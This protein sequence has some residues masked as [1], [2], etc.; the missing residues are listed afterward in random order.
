MGSPKVTPLSESFHNGGFIVSEVGPG[1]LS[2]EQVILS[3]GAKAYAGAVLGKVA[4]GTSSATAGMAASGLINLAINP[5]DG[6]TVTIVGTAITF[7]ASGASGNFQVNIGTTPTLT[8]AALVALLTAHAIATVTCTAQGNTGIL[9][10]ASSVGTAGNSIALATSNATAIVLSGATLSGGVVGNTGNAT[11]SGVTAGSLVK[12]GTYTAVCLTATTASVLD[13][14][15][16]VLGTL[17][18]GT[19]FLNAQI[20]LTITAGNTPCAAGDTFY[21]FPGVGAGVYKPVTASATDGSEEAAAILYET[22]DVTSADAPV[23]IMARLCEVNASE[24]VWDA[25]MTNALQAVAIAQLAKKHI[26]CR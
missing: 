17:T 21:I 10:S 7:K 20:G 24:L 6:D 23:T 2:R 8:A 25:S 11:I 1:H 9:V 12:N 5:S 3:G 16:E 26:I 19:A 4:F 22:K 13:P 18:F 15:G 14:D